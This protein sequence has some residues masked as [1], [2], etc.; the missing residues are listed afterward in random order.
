[1]KSLLLEKQIDLYGMNLMK[2]KQ[3]LEL[4]TGNLSIHKTGIMLSCFFTKDKKVG[5]IKFEHKLNQ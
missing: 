1:M 3:S 2:V 5:W 4:K